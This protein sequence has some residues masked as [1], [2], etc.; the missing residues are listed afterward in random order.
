LQ[1]IAKIVDGEI[2]RLTEYC[3][4]KLSTEFREPTYLV[5]ASL[6]QGP[7][8]GYAII[9]RASELS[10]G[11]VNLAVATLYGAL[12]RL[13]TEDLIELL[14]EEI[15]DGRA[16]RTFALTK[17]GSDHVLRQAKQLSLLASAVLEPAIGVAGAIEVFA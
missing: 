8:H 14:S 4:M 11:R 9:Q 15:V 12:D 5:L 10:Q 3:F 2:P 6:R 1:N 17:R 13:R 7:T 16:R